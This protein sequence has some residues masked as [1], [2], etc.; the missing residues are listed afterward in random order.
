AD[1]WPES[2]TLSG[3]TTTQRTDC[4]LEWACP[5]TSRRSYTRQSRESFVDSSRSTAPGI[6]QPRP[7]L[8]E[9]SL[10]PRPCTNLSSGTLAWRWYRQSRGRYARFVLSN[11]YAVRFGSLGQV[12]A[13]LHR[14]AGMR[15]GRVLGCFVSSAPDRVFRLG[16]DH[17][18]VEAQLHQADFMMV[19][20]MRAYR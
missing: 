10:A 4:H 16:F 5:R 7:A 6:L 11:R 15:T 20:R 19:S 2:E 1:D 18:E 14:P 3:T 17:V 8:R 9:P 12:I 13:L